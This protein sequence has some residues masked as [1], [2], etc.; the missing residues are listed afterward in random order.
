MYSFVKKPTSDADPWEYSHVYD[1]EIH[2]S[3][4]NDNISVKHF[5]YQK[6]L[7]LFNHGLVTQW[8]QWDLTKMEKQYNLYGND[9]YKIVTNKNQT[10]LALHTA[11]DDKNKKI[12]I[13]S[14]ET[15]VQIS[16]YG[17]YCF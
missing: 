1:I 2:K 12:D 11:S 10:L 8:D 4:K 17:W 14:M 15:G 9:V 16:S 7:F 5:V 6:K 3:L 13:Y